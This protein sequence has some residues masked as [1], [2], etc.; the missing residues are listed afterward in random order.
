ML[1]SKLSLAK[2]AYLV[3][4]RQLASLIGTIISM[5]IAL[6][7]VTRLMTRSLYAVLNDRVSWCQKLTLS[8]EATD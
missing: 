5:S 8:K 1:R 2:Q 4:A 6:C 3:S 7:P